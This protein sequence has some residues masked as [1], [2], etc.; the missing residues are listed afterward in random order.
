MGCTRNLVVRIHAFTRLLV[1]ACAV[2]AQANSV[3]PRTH[4]TRARAHI[5]GRG[6]RGFSPPLPRPSHHCGFDQ[7]PVLR[8]IPLSPG[9]DSQTRIHDAG[10]LTGAGVSISGAL[11]LRQ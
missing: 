9:L 4:A 3:V 8:L 7:C 1:R 2:L 6:K 5:P 10:S 11:C